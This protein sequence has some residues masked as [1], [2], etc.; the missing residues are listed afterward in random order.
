M[1]GFGAWSGG[2]PAPAPPRSCRDL[3]VGPAP[4]AGAIA[5][6]RTARAQRQTAPGLRI[7]SRHA[8]KNSAAPRSRIGRRGGR[9]QLSFDGRSTCLESIP[10]EPLDTLREALDAICAAVQMRRLRRVVAEVGR[11]PG[12]GPTNRRSCPL[13][14]HAGRLP[15]A[16]RVSSRHGS[17]RF[18]RRAFARLHAVPEESARQPPAVCWIEP[19][20]RAMWPAVPC[21]CV[22]PGS[23]ITALRHWVA[24][25]RLTSALPTTPRLARQGTGRTLATPS[26]QPHYRFS[27]PIPHRRWPRCRFR[28]LSLPQLAAPPAMGRPKLAA[29]CD[30]RRVVTDGTSYEVAALAM[31]R[32]AHRGIH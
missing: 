19:P 5:P 25:W 13:S 32:K 20:S 1:R 17:G 16:P 22:C 23:A 31:N 15:P 21:R 30:R 9:G 27:Y 14:E 12:F 2:A 29:F 10:A 6:N 24:W 28:R 7:E 4:G 26:R 8:G 3:P 18:L 11:E